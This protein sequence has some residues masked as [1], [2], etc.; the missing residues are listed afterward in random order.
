MG[1]I[2]KDL[3][4]LVLCRKGSNQRPLAEQMGT[5]SAA[6]LGYVMQNRHFASK[7]R[8]ISSLLCKLGKKLESG[9]FP[10]P[11]GDAKSS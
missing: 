8:L 4:Q 10:E 11:P 2:G 6:L 5:S 7:T 3:S 9:S 1:K